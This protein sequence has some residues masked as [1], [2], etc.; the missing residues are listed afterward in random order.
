MAWKETPLP[1]L[2]D[3]GKWENL[4]QWME[5]VEIWAIN[6]E[7]PAVCDL[8]AL[9]PG[10]DDMVDVSGDCRQA[11]A[12]SLLSRLKTAWLKNDFT[13]FVNNKYRLAR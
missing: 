2:D 3:K 13:Q 10:V 1:I 5:Q 12:K 8:Q 7:Y 6:P 11:L 4:R 9:Q